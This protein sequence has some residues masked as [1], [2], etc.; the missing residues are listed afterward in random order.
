MIVGLLVLLGALLSMIDNKS[1]YVYS[2]LI[3]LLWFISSFTYGN[4]DETIYISRYTNIEAWKRNTEL[5]YYCLIKFANS[6]KLSYVQFKM[7]T[8]TIELTLISSTV[9]KYSKRPNLVILFYFVFPFLISVAQMRNALATSIFIY[10]L[11]FLIEDLHRESFIMKKFLTTNELKYIIGIVIAAFVH[12]SAL[13]W[14]LLLIPLKFN[15]KIVTI[16]TII[17]SCS[18]AFLNP[19][20]LNKILLLFGTSTRMSAYTSEAY[21]ETRSLLLNGALFRTFLFAMIVFIFILYLRSFGELSDEVYFLLKVNTILLTVLPIIYFYTPEM[22][23]AQVDTSLLFYIVAFNTLSDKKNNG[24][25]KITISLK[26]FIV[27]F[28][29]IFFAVSSLYLLILR[30]NYETVFYPIFHNNSLFDIFR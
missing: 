21:A 8:S 20:T 7:L 13:F 18:V 28:I 25:K 2:Y 19:T 11:R 22:Y 6:I 10:S 14:L 12:T 1:R 5:L 4:A 26:D 23:R 17:I 15:E 27:F 29:L 3:L 16:S 24:L 30:G 9:L